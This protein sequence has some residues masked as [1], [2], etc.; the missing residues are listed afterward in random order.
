MQVPVHIEYSKS[1]N[2]LK[3][4]EGAEVTLLNLLTHTLHEYFRMMKDIGNDKV[5][6]LIN[7]SRGTL[8]H[9]RE[10]LD[11]LTSFPA[12]RTILLQRSDFPSLRDGRPY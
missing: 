1:L 4:L 8:Q 9:R 11:T 10:M 3:E 12:W 7:F 2:L 6:G 5:V